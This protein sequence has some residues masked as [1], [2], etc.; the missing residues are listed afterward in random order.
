MNQNSSHRIFLGLGANL[1]NAQDNILQAIQYIQARTSVIRVSSFY[2]SA[3]FSDRTQPK[4]TNAVCELESDLSLQEIYRFL[5]G[6]EGR[7]GRAVIEQ[8]APRPIDIDILFYDDVITDNNQDPKIPYPNLHK[9]PFYLMP[10]AEINS[11]KIHPSMDMSVQKLL[12]QSNANG[13]KKIDRSLKIRLDNDVQASKPKICVSISR[14][15]VTNL[16]RNI[17]IDNDGS[18]ALFYAN[19]DLF[20]DLNAKQAGVHMSR[21]SDVLE[22]MVED[23]SL[24]PSSDIESLAARLARQV[25]KTQGAICSEVHIRAQSPT[26]KITPISGKRIEELFTLVGIAASTRERTRC[27]IGVETQGMTVCPCAQ[28]MIKS[29][30]VR[31]L[32]EDGYPEKE[33]LRILDLLPIAS[34][35]QRG[36]GTLL[37]G[38]DQRIRAENLLHIVEASMSSETYELLKRPDEFFV[39]NKAHRNPKFVED[40][41]REMLKNVIDVYPDLPDNSF[42]MV[43]QENF[44]GIHQ[45]NAF[46]ER[47]GTLAE[48]RREIFKSIHPPR[49]TT[50]QEWLRQ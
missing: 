12:E 40:V 24:D 2:E 33:A 5:K 14:V 9:R 41:V 20:A 1:G 31:L 36:R 13:V 45:H 48:I 29:H 44:E 18:G 27:I 26:T 21:F 46:A 39:V 8:H 22:S 37:I 15:G 43:K 16:R 7:M 42:V 11:S 25:V 6:I 47:Y 38:T 49:Q 32:R 19:I 4:Y 30:S 35:N 3:S 50:M 17:R 10:L 28:D 23:I 34:H